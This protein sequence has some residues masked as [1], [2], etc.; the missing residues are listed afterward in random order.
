M[1]RIDHT[2]LHVKGLHRSAKIDMA[3]TSLIQA[4]WMFMCFTTNL[5]A[6]IQTP[7][8][9]IPYLGHNENLSPSSAYIK[10]KPSDDVSV[11][12]ELPELEDSPTP[13]GGLTIRA[14]SFF[15]TVGIPEI[16]FIKCNLKSQG[17]AWF[18]IH[19]ITNLEYWNKT[20]AAACFFSSTWNIHTHKIENRQ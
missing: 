16:S 18:P 9:A 3:W 17:L 12:L 5:E 4:N 1:V 2:M 19:A 8:E 15:R 13:S 20:S 10:Q 7:W 6:N 14:G 11:F